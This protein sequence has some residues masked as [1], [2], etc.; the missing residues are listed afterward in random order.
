M[1]CT[2][3][4]AR[5]AASP[6]RLARH[7]K[8]TGLYSFRT[9]RGGQMLIRLCGAGSRDTPLPPTCAAHDRRLPSIN[10]SQPLA[11]IAARADISPPFAVV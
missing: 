7:H 11:A 1:R 5:I 10:I 8:P 2:P 6:A 3:L 4:A 9:L